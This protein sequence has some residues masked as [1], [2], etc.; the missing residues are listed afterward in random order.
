MFLR[1]NVALSFS[2]L[3]IGLI[4]SIVSSG[5]LDGKCEMCSVLMNN[6]IICYSIRKL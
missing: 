1:R 3:T 2:N 4:L 5:L 6:Y